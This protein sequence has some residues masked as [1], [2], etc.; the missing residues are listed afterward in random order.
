MEVPTIDDYEA[1]KKKAKEFYVGIGRVWCPALDDYI[2]FNSHGFR[3]LLRKQGKTRL[4]HEQRRRFALLGCV[5]NILAEPATIFVHTEG[6]ISQLVK[7]RGR[8]MTNISPADFWT[9]RAIRDTGM[10]TI[11]LRAFWMGRKHFF[12]VY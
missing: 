12:S 3:H 10:I 1:T 9:C 11:V 7:W 8:K 2:F 4:I 6:N 5:P